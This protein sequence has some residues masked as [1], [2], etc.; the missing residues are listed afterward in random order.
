[1]RIKRLAA[2]LAAVTVLCAATAAAAGTWHKNTWHLT[3]RGAFSAYF[4]VGPNHSG[5]PKTFFLELIA[6]DA[7]ALSNCKL[8]LAGKTTSGTIDAESVFY[9][10]F[11]WPPM[12][13]S[14]KA[15]ATCTVNKVGVIIRVI[16]VFG[17]TD[18]NLRRA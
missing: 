6:S 1:M 3:R 18:V 14:A 10:N 8:H 15:T 11:G 4:R 2:V 5:Q 16:A 7:T 9:V 12:G 17:H 13:S